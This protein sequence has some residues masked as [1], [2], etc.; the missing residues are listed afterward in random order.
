[1]LSMYILNS[2]HSHYNPQQ[3]T[4]EG[5]VKYSM[6]TVLSLVRLPLLLY[7]DM[8]CRYIQ[9]IASTYIIVQTLDGDVKDSMVDFAV[10]R[11]I[12]VVICRQIYSDPS[13]YIIILSKKRL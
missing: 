2:Q 5:D 3:K 7:V 8:C 4:L 13:T 10:T 12:L 6:S 9:L 11:Q 1:M